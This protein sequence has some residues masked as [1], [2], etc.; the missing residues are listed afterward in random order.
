MEKIKKIMKNS[1]F[2]IILVII[3]K[4]LTFFNVTNDEYYLDLV[5]VEKLSKLENDVIDI[6]KKIIEIEKLDESIFLNLLDID[7]ND[8]VIN[9]ID[10][11]LEGIEKKMLVLDRMVSNKQLLYHEI[12]NRLVDFDI[13][14][15]PSISPVRTKNLLRISSEFGWRIHPI[16]KK[17]IFHQGLDIVVKENVN[18]YSTTNGYVDKVMYSKYGYGNRVVVKNDSGYETLFAH[19]SNHIY[20][21]EGDYV[22]KGQLIAKSG[23]TGT[24]TGNHLHYE[25]RKDNIPQ[26]P[27]KFFKIY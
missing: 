10:N 22:K 24:S 1:I 7:K 15:Y 21:K 3:L 9:D 5:R 25:I 16:Y 2:I 6:Q 18:I 27:L 12:N 13:N 17:P 23:N 8:Y 4:T 26:N 20:I 19:L 14:N 11:S